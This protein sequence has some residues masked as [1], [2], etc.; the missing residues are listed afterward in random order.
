MSGRALL[1]AAGL[2]LFA[3]CGEEASSPPDPQPAERPGAL[4]FV[5]VTAVSGVDFVHDN[6]RSARRYLP[7]TMGAGLAV[8]DGDGDGLP[9]LFF[10]DSGPVA[11]GGA[12]RPGALYRNLGGLRFEAAGARSGLDQPILGQGVAVGDVDNDGDPDLLITGVGAD[13]LYLNQGNGTFRP[14]RPEGW[15]EPGFSSSAAFLDFDRDGRLD[16]F[17]GRYITWSPQTDVACRP[18]GEHRTYCT[19]EVYDGESNRLLRNLGDGRFADVTRSAGLYRPD[20]KTL[21]VVPIDADADGWPDLA[22]AN[23]TIGNFLFVNQGDGTFQEVGT[24]LGI[25]FGPSG[26][27]RG[28]MGIDAGDLDGDGLPDLLVANFAQEMSAVFVSSP[29]GLWTDSAAALGVGLPS[30]MTLAFGALLTDLDL[31]GSLDAVLANGHIE[32]EIDR[33]Q[34]TQSYA[35]P[36]AVFHGRPEG[37]DEVPPDEAPAGELIGRALAAAD[38]DGDGDLDL[39]VTQNGG[40]PR[41]LENRSSVGSWV[42]LVPRGE[43]GHRAAYG[44]W[45]EATIGERRVAGSL[46]SGRSYLTAM[47][48]ALTLGLGPG[49]VERL[50]VT[51]PSQ[52][53]QRL[54]EPPER[55]VLVLFER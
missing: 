51:W 10:V 16:L 50:D 9:D 31:D 7:E 22:V 47:E 20:G 40:P 42:R 11:A 54:L 26:A 53:R 55:R 44:L 41:I 39:V 5:D 25:A 6:G 23:D 49:G 13:H 4:T 19:P 45:A 37:F 1:L 48:A 8:F 14:A 38:L 2:G 32:P 33:Y 27:P 30:L 46:V 18:D 24:E 52:R 43:L 36:L 35:Q 3:G 34:A 12:R 28:S 15:P 17:L 29:S 21:G